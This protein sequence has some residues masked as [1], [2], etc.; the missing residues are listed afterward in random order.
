[1][2]AA[3]IAVLR[4]PVD[5]QERVMLTRDPDAPHPRDEDPAAWENDPEYRASRRD[6]EAAWHDGRVYRLRLQR[7]GRAV[8]THPLDAV[9][10]APP[11]YAWHDV[12]SVGGLYLD[13]PDDTDALLALAAERWEGWKP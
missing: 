10:V 2:S 7:R 12:D 3:V 1:M 11:L 8:T 6:D 5:E 4:H 13:Q 9:V